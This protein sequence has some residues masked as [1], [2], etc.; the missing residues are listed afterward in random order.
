VATEQGIL[1]SRNEGGW[2]Q[3]RGEWGL[4]RA[5]VSGWLQSRGEW[6]ATE[7]M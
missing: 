2:L 6:L 1:Q 5:D 3:R 7:Q 4:Y